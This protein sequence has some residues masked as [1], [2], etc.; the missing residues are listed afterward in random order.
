MSTI[1]CTPQE[2]ASLIKLLNP[3]KTTGP[4]GLSNEML[5]V[6]AKEIAIP[7]SIF[8]NRSFKDGRFAE[9][10]KS[11][12]F[13][14]FIQKNDRTKLSTT[15]TSKVK[16]MQKLRRPYFLHVLILAWYLGKTCGLVLNRLPRNPADVNTQKYCLFL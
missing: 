14:S 16:F 13:P 2:I 7:Q 9:V 11:Y 10:Y 3:N 4:G 15:T 12:I 6:V 1:S 5:N 8:F